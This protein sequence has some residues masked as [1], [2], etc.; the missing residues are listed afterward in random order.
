M[1]NQTQ[2]NPMIRI[3]LIL[4]PLLSFLIPQRWLAF[5]AMLMI[6]MA[7]VQLLM[8]TLLAEE[9]SAAYASFGIELVLCYIAFNVALLGVRYLLIRRARERIL[10][11]PAP[12]E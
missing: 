7:I 5:Y 6:A 10:K 3:I 4:I 11:L 12:K 2:G 8:I 1:E 9:A